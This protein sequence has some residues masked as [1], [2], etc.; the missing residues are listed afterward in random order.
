MPVTGNPLTLKFYNSATDSFLL[1]AVIIARYKDQWVFC[2]HKKRTTL[3]IPGGRREKGETIEQTARRELYEETGASTYTLKQL[4][5]YSVIEKGV[6]SFGM[7]YYADIYEFDSLPESEMEKILLLKDLPPIDQW[8][9]PSLQPL[10]M[11][12]YMNNK[13]AR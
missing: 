11:G 8:T 10:M 6:E 4:T 13:K 12:I 9:Y 1:Y 2:K 5:P 3:E 7:I